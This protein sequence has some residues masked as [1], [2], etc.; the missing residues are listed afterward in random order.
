[1]SSTPKQPAGSTTKT[2][3]E[4]ILS[5]LA[6]A[7]GYVTLALT[8]AGVVIP[9][10]KAAIQKIEG[11]GTANV[12]I[13]FTDLV[14][15]DQAELLAIVQEAEADLTAVNAELARQGLPTIAAPPAGS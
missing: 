5:I 11:L 4:S 15:A 2:T 9:L 7:N 3:A 6:G 13:T 14:A 12:T 10:A 1:M 8:A